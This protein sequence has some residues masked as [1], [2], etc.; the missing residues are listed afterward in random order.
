M[1]A[2]TLTSPADQ[3]AT[4]VE[5]FFD[6]VFVFAITQITH[7]AAHHLDGPGLFRAGVVF[8]LVW[9]GWTQFTWSLNAADTDHH[10]VRVGTLV[11]TGLAFVMAASVERAYSAEAVPALTFALSYIAVRVLG[12]GLYYRVASD[13][14]GQR[15]DVSLF[16]L[17]SLG[18]LVAVLVGG[19][20]DP[21]LREWIWAGAILLD[22]FAAGMAGNRAH[23][24]LHAGHFA[25][26]HGLIIIIALGES[27]IVAGSAL[28]GEVDRTLMVTGGLAVAATCLLWWTYF[29]WIQGVLEE[30][31]KESTGKAR[32]QLGRDAYTLWHFPLVSGIIA[33]AVGFEAAFHPGDYSTGQVA[34]AAGVGLSLFLLSTAGALWRAERCVLWNRLVVL[35]LTVG[36]VT[37]TSSSTPIA[38]LT[39]ASVGLAVIVVFEQVTVRR[40]L[41]AR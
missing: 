24:G 41:A 1:N 40:R 20:V 12:L 35:A 29:G 36:A 15:S 7:Y 2:K 37:V 32:S 18:G 8:W 17:L 13:N 30:R 14:E 6:L 27:L 33:L 28:T 25:E 39:I 3:G 9:W 5:L 10:Q 11:A 26:R 4:F 31:L 38:L 23:W 21:S 34:A 16:A 22:I 19:L